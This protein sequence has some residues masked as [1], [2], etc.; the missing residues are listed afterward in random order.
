MLYTLVKDTQRTRMPVDYACQYMQ[1]RVDTCDRIRTAGGLPG[2]YTDSGATVVPSANVMVSPFCNLPKSCPAD[3][4]CAFALSG[5]N[6]PRTAGPITRYETAKE[7]EAKRGRPDVFQAGDEYHIGRLFG[8]PGE[9]AGCAKAGLPPR[10]MSCRTRDR[11]SLAGIPES[12][13]GLKL[14]AKGSKS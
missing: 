2:S 8:G 1:T 14:R 7:G 12:C 9:L 4:P 3:T 13:D 6:L 5:L 10:N 11:H